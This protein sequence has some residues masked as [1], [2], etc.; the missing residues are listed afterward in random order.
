MHLFEW[1]DPALFD[2]GTIIKIVFDLQNTAKR[3]GW[4]AMREA[5]I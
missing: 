5:A 2:Q 1:S 3:Q 4:R